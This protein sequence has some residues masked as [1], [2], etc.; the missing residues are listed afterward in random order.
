MAEPGL[1][2]EQEEKES[3]DRASSAADEQENAPDKKI[4]AEHEE[5]AVISKETEKKPQLG[6]K[7]KN[8][9]KAK[10]VEPETLLVDGKEVCL[11]E[12]IKEHK[13]LLEGSPSLNKYQRKAIRRYHREEALKPYQAELIRMQN[14]LELN[15]RR[16]II[17]FEGRDAAGKGGTIRRVTR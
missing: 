7:K 6:R 2:I 1:D 8:Q 5:S 11:K 14:Y 17:L 12:F 10:D 9:K 3:L 4:A 13:Q 15:K 16:M